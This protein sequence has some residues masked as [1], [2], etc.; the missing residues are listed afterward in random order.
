MSVIKY[1]VVLSLVW[2]MTL[3]EF[4]SYGGLIFNTIVQLEQITIT[5]YNTGVHVI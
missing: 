4:N 3:N 5:K 1:D 2:S